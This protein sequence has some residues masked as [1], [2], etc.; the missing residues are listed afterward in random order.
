MLILWARNNWG[1]EITLK[2]RSYMG[3]FGTLA[4]YLGLLL[5]AANGAKAQQTGPAT[6]LQVP[7]YVSLKY[8]RVN[9]REGPSREHRTSWVFQR[10]GLPIE[11]TAEFE[12]WR[13]VRDSE[14]TEGWVLQ[15]V[16]SGRRTALVSPWKK[17]GLMI[18]QAKA[19]SGETAA[20]LQPGVIANIKSCDDKFCHIFG[21]GYDGY[22]EKTALWGVYPDEKIP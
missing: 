11:I 10:A 4:C 1:N 21:E 12:N 8:D 13:R 18:L 9:L 5:C 20:R 3:R 16:L 14:G 6:G 17:D 2:S 22:L 15:T 7:R 19:G